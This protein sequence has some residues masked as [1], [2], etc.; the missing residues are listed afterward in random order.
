M[1][2]LNLWIESVSNTPISCV[3]AHRYVS[4]LAETERKDFLESNIKVSFIRLMV[5]STITLCR[6]RLPQ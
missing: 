4:A 6:Y 3:M 5:R 2:R 1:N